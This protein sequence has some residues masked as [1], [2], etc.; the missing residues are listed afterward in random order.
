MDIAYQQVVSIARILEGMRIRERE[1]RK[2]KRPRDSGM[3]NSSRAPSTTRQGRGCGSRPVHSAL[4][5]SSG[6]LAIPRPQDPYYAPPVS[7]VPPVQN[8]SSGKSNRSGPSQSHQLRPPRACFECG[9][10]RHM[11]RDFPKL[12]KGA[13]LEISQAPPIPRG[14]QASQAMIT[15]SVATPPAQLAGDASVLFDPGSTYSYVSSY[16]APYLGVSHDSLSSSVDVA[17]LVGDS[18]IVDGVYQSC[19]IVI[20]G[21][22]TRADLLLLSMVNFEIILGMDWLSPYHTILDCYAKTVT[23]AMPGLPRL[24]WR[25]TLDH[26]PS[27]VVSFIKDQ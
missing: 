2:A 27:R 8:V 25:G 6:T 19:F 1:E 20:S 4:P 15:A 22:E 9:D 17:T 11:V 3:Y 7:S 18:I 12:R 24:E 16:F 14:P 13:P 5:V 10:T 26:I 21:F 23:L